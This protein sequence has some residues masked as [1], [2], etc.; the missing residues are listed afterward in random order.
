MAGRASGTKFMLSKTTSQW[1]HTGPD[2]HST[3]TKLDNGRSGASQWLS[4]VVLRLVDRPSEMFD[5]V[6]RHVSIGWT[7]KVGGTTQWPTRSRCGWLFSTLVGAKAVL[8][9]Y[10]HRMFFE[11]VILDSVK[12]WCRTLGDPVGWTCVRSGGHRPILVMIEKSRT[13][14]APSSSDPFIEATAVSSVSR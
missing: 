8:E 4:A 13:T 5:H 2:Y 12:N 14:T 3:S 7:F 9:E 1:I 6:L 10:S 11:K